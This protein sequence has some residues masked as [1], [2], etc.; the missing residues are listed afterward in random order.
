MR[1]QTVI[2]KMLTEGC[3]KSIVDSG[4]YFGYQYEYRRKRNL[5]EDPVMKLDWV[6]GTDGSLDGMITKSM[7]HHMCQHLHYEADLT[8]KLNRFFRKQGEEPQVNTDMFEKFVKTMKGYLL[9]GSDNTYNHD[10]ILDGCF[11]YTHFIDPWDDTCDY[12]IVC[13][14]NGAAARWGYSSPKV[15]NT[16]DYYGFMFPV[17]YLDCENGCPDFEFETDSTSFKFDKKDWSDKRT[18]GKIWMVNNE[19]HWEAHCPECGGRL[20][21]TC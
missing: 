5:E 12:F 21:A 9:C 20:I 19:E 16:P 14:H 13:S 11:C 6:Y 7:Y 18:P 10:S 3:G 4:S 1:I 15:F 17:T 8:R 2:R